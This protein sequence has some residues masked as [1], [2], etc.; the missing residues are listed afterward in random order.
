MLRQRLLASLATAA[1]LG[2]IA[3]SS[4]QAA[5]D[6]LSESALRGALLGEV[7]PVGSTSRGINPGGDD[8]GMCSAGI[9]R[10]IKIEFPNN[11]FSLTKKAKANL[12]TLAAV[13]KDAEGKGLTFEISGHTNATGKAEYNDWLSQKRAEAVTSY[14]IKD[15]GIPGT[16][17]EPVGAGSNEP[18]PGVSPKDGKNRRVQVKRVE[19]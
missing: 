16:M 8:D 15:K 11:K 14:L 6:G 18:L 7:A 2:T 9:C 13:L 17:L 3:A 4:V 1:L 5:G 12:N 19:D 10:D